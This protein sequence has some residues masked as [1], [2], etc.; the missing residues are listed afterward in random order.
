MAERAKLF[1]YKPLGEVTGAAP[2]MYAR[3]GTVMRSAE[4][5]KQMN[6]DP[7]FYPEVCNFGKLGVEVHMY[8]VRYGPDTDEL[9]LAGHRIST[10]RCSWQ[11]A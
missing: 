10:A 1:M 3:D 8:N 6:Q 9:R 11:M 5:W 2:N 4:E 7:L